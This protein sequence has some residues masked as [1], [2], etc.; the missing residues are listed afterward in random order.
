VKA[1]MVT[2]KRRGEGALA[3]TFG[4]LVAEFDCVSDATAK[5]PAA[6][7]PSRAEVS[8]EVR[9]SFNAS[10]LRPPILDYTLS[11]SSGYTVR[12]VLSDAL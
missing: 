9:W 12:L 8:A 1:Q 2:G 4:Q 7:A 5:G 3:R 11:S 6:R 10:A